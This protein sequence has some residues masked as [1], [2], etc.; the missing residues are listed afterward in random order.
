LPFV[1][2]LTH[3]GAPAQVNTVLSAQ[4]APDVRDLDAV[5]ELVEREDLRD[6]TLVGHS[7]GGA[8]R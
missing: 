6:V 2:R 7:W 3:T 5:V 1:F 4:G 8:T